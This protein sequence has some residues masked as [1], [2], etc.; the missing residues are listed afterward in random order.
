MRAAEV[1]AALALA[2]PAA[3][4]PRHRNDERETA[5]ATAPAAAVAG[6]E[7]ADPARL[8][9]TY[10]SGDHL[11]PDDAGDLAMANVVPAVGADKPAIVNG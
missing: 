8:A 3:A 6:V 10:D 2:T 11:H 1:F 7:Q 4:A 9:A 5:W